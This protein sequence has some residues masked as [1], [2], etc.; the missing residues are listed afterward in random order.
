M[1]WN[2]YTIQRY[3]ADYKAA[4][5][6]LLSMTLFS[7]GMVAVMI[8]GTLRILSLVLTMWMRSKKHEIDI[9]TFLGTSKRM[10]LT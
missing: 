1:D 5:K 10:I 7:V 2:Y 9:L 8:I 3:D 4:A 6:P